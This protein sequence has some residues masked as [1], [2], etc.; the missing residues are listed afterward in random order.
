MLSRQ[1]LATREMFSATLETEDFQRAVE[2]NPEVMQE[3]ILLA[4]K[5]KW[6]NPAQLAKMVREEV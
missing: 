6:I 5:R 1:E 3:I 2:A 4:A